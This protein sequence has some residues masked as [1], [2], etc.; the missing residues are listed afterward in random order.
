LGAWSTAGGVAKLP[1]VSTAELR[2]HGAGEVQG[3]GVDL[4]G[5]AGAGLLHAVLPAERG[6][7]HPLPARHGPLLAAVP[8]RRRLPGA[9]PARQQPQLPGPAG[10]RRRRALQAGLDRSAAGGAQEALPARGEGNGLA[11]GDARRAAAAGRP[12]GAA[13]GGAGRPAGDAP[14]VRDDLRVRRAAGRR[15]D[16][17]PAPEGRRR[18]G[19]Q[20]PLRGR[21]PRLHGVRLRAGSVQRRTE[22]R[23]QLRP[24][25][26][27]ES[28][29]E[30]EEEEEEGLWRRLEQKVRYR[31]TPV[32]SAE[33]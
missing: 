28:V 31:R 4:S 6:G 25:A 16:V 12:G 9:R 3:P 19:D 30:E 17:R 29:E 8:G 11:A 15:V 23:R 22:E 2:R 26:G 27:P 7:A 1:L 21:L 24:L 33:R 32:G 20:R 18:R 5:A 14:S 10:R 13:A